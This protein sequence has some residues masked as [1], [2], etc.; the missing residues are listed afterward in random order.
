[1]A[2]LLSPLSLVPLFS[3]KMMR[4]ALGCLAMTLLE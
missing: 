3:V 1:M 4:I 2:L